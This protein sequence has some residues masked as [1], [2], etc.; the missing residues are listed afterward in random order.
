MGMTKLTI[1]TTV[2]P[3]YVPIADGSPEAMKIATIPH[4]FNSPVRMILSLDILMQK[5]IISVTSP[6]HRIEIT[7]K[8]KVADYFE[9]KAKFEGDTKKMD[10]DL[11]VYI[12]SEDPHQPRVMVEK[13]AMDSHVA[14]L[15]FVPDF[16]LAEHQMEAIFLVD[17][18]GSMRGTSMDLAKEA[19]LVFLHSL[20][21]RS[22]FNVII[23][24][25]N[26]KSLFP[27]S[28][29]YDDHSFQDAKTSIQGKTD[30]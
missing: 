6:S 10:R 16:H 7:D 3:R 18:S 30:L 24:G 19:L 14:M 13:D 11:I 29:I 5:E 17:C 26:Y 15:T 2:A 8:T 9:T 27:E 4:D 21:V 1:P 22:Y 23:F 25:S 12:K 20:P 28:R